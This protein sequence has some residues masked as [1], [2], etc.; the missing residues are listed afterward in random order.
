MSFVAWNSSMRFM[1]VWPWWDDRI[2]AIFYETPHDGDNVHEGSLLSLRM[3]CLASASPMLSSAR[4][5]ARHHMQLGKC[6]H[7]YHGS[8]G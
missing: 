7:G 5:G 4:R 3:M 6:N 1:V 2:T 8:R